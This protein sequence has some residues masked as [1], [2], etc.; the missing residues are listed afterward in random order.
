M[1]KLIGSL[2]LASLWSV[3]TSAGETTSGDIG[4]N[5]LKTHECIVSTSAQIY[6][7]PS[8][9]LK[10]IT[11]KTI[12]FKV[13]KKAHEDHFS[14][15]INDKK[16]NEKTG[17]VELMTGTVL[18]TSDGDVIQAWA[19]VKIF[20][21]EID[22]NLVMSINAPFATTTS[23]LSINDESNR[24]MLNASLKCQIEKSSSNKYMQKSNHQNLYKY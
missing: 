3:S 11:G 21:K 19:K 6:K 13:T 17:E 8:F 5:T 14:L 12:F 24:I 9:S 22:L 18:D 15:D 4:R 20:N 7:K 2:L 23:H 10:I 1:K 16:S